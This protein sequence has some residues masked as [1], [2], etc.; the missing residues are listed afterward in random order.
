V[1]EKKTV[2][3]VGAGASKEF[4]MPTGEELR[5]D[6]VALISRQA[7]QSNSPEGSE[8]RAVLMNTVPEEFQIL[9]SAGIELAAALPT[10]ISID[11]AL[12]YFSSNENVVRIGKLT[13]AY[14]LLR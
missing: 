8:F 10:F 12:H 6:I 2:F 11:E 13:L 5:D 9:Q 1:F 4:E 3:V 7:W 14:L